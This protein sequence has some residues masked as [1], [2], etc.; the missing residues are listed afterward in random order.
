VGYSCS[1]VA[2]VMP[3]LGLYEEKHGHRPSSSAPGF[4]NAVEAF[5]TESKAAIKSNGLEEDFLPDSD[6]R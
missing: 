5:V 3:V 2:C 4:E 6:L 1:G